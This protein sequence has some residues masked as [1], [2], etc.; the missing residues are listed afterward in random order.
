VL[1]YELD[2]GFQATRQQR[3]GVLVLWDAAIEQGYA[4]NTWL[5]YRQAASLG[6][7]V[8]KGERAVLCAHFG[9]LP[10]GESQCTPASLS[11]AATLSRS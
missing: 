6:A 11:C 9:N 8:R 7:Q 10:W 1:A 4:S 3:V 5:T 2:V